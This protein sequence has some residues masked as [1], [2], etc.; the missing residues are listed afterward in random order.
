MYKSNSIQAYTT[1]SLTSCIVAESVHHAASKVNN[2]K[3]CAQALK[4]SQQKLC[5]HYKDSKLYI[6]YNGY[7]KH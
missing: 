6:Y 4:D 5:T 3:N 1:P 7:Q 2:T